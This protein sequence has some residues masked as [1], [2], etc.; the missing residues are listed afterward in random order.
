MTRERLKRIS[1]LLS[2]VAWLFFATACVST[3]NEGGLPAAASLF[4]LVVFSIFLLLDLVATRDLDRP[5]GG[6]LPKLYFA[7]WGFVGI[8]SGISM[9]SVPF[10]PEIGVR[11]MG[12]RALILAGVYAVA[13]AFAVAKILIGRRLLRRGAASGRF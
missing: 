8:L 11:A 9:C 10:S 7:Q 4:M 13:T 1:A 6:C 12:W 2:G 5:R 3:M